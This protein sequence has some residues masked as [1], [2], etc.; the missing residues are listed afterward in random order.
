M[1]FNLFS[2]LV[3]AETETEAEIR[4]RFS[5]GH[6]KLFRSVTSFKANCPLMGPELTG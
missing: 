4:F 1:N 5:F 3:S 6:K 2:V